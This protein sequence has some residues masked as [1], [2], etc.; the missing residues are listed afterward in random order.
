MLMNN[1][2]IRLVQESDM[3]ELM[4]LIDEHAT[5]EK[6]A[7]NSEG[8][9]ERLKIELFSENSRL[10]C[11]VIELGGKVNG[12]CSFTVDYSTWDAA[13]FIYMDCLYLRSD[14]RGAGI[15]SAILKKLQAFAA[16]NHLV[17]IQWQTPNFNTSAIA[18]YKKNGA[19]SSNKVR[20]TLNV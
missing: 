19:F 13:Y 15:G 10:K 9:K 18:F 11:W 5:F 8:K 2:F 1:Y 17:N 6:S 20:F 4:L 12:Y 16:E 14:L 7:Y 3:E